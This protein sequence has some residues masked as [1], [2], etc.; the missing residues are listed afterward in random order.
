MYLRCHLLVGALL[1]AACGDDGNAADV[2][3]SSLDFGHTDCGTQAVTRSITITNESGDAFNF[4]TALAAGADSMYTVT[5]A[6]GAVLPSSQLT[7]EIVS[8]P[9]PAVSAVTD[10]LYGDTL[11]ITTDQ[12]GNKA[13]AVAI[14]QTA[15]GVYLEAS[16]GAINFGTPLQPGGSAD[17]PLMIT[18]IGNVSTEVSVVSDL[19]PAFTLTQ[20][21]TLTLAPAA[22]GAAT[23]HFS[24]GHTGENLGTLSVTSQSVA[25][26]CSAPLEVS[27]SGIGTAAGMAVHAVPAGLRT[28]QRE[29]GVGTICTLLTNGMVACG[30]DN[31]N[32]ARGAPDEYMA[33]IPQ[34]QSGK[35]GGGPAPTGGLAAHD[36][37][38]FVQTKGDYLNGIVQLASGTNQF[39]GRRATG[40]VLCWGDIDGKGG[41]VEQTNPGV[42]YHPFATRVIAA[43]ATNLALGYQYRCITSGANSTMS[44]TTGRSGSNAS[45]PPSF[46]TVD[47]A[48]QV[49]ISGGTAYALVAGEVW[50]FGRSSVG[51]RG[52]SANQS[53][54]GAAIP[55]FTDNAQVVA[56]GRGVNRDNRWACARKSDGTVFCWG[57]NRHGQIGDGNT[58][59]GTTAV[60]QVIDFEDEN[61]TGTSEL[62]AGNS[63]VC[64]LKQG[65]VWCWGRG[66]EG[67]M[68]NGT[69]AQDNTKAVEVLGITTATKIDASGTRG[70]CA[71]LANHSVRCWGHIA[72]TLYNV[73]TPIA[74]FEP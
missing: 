64:A 6:A 11:T 45:T 2:V 41:R 15:R 10:N 46:W 31:R 24:P 49:A 47:N 73:A 18:N 7:I 17:M 35:G 13:Y 33:H 68:G 61:L 43:G 62:T 63:H 34:P 74:A 4:T 9:I 71:V 50:S 1:L 66:Q 22:S 16:S 48:T 57:D 39:C 53:D 69:A 25:P 36:V 27:A 26:V 52:Y 3:V 42:R 29:G 51:E 54:P 67:Q 56:G 59:N 8:R 40:E 20:G 60:S 58:N 12:E 32:G 19:A 28:R 44:C 37:V 5:P 30:G 55:S 70:T 72:S 38:N 23:V 21:A 65:S 14:T